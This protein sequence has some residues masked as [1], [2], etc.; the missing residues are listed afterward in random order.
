MHI[1]IYGEAKGGMR[2]VLL[3][4][5]IIIL[6]NHSPLSHCTTLYLNFHAGVQ[7]SKP[8]FWKSGTDFLEKKITF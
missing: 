2:Y 5:F 1:S 6:N 7:E 8:D 3:L 4:F